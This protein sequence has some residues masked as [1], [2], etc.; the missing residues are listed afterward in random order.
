M[1]LILLESLAD[2]AIIK[3]ADGAAINFLSAGKSSGRIWG[4]AVTLSGNAFTMAKGA[5]MARGYRIKCDAST[6][7]LNLGSATLPSSDTAYRLIARVTRSGDSASLAIVYQIASSSLSNDLIEQGN[8]TYDMTIGTFKMGPGGVSDFA[9]SLPTLS[10]GGGGGSSQGQ[11]FG[12]T[13]PAPQLEIVRK[14]TGGLDDGIWLCLKNKGDYTG[15]MTNYT[16]VLKL[17]R[18]R[19]RARHRER[20]GTSKVYY[21]KEGWHQSH[22]GLKP[23]DPNLNTPIG[24]STDLIELA[25][26]TIATQGNFSYTRKDV[27]CDLGDV[28]DALWY[29]V[30]NGSKAHISDDTSPYA[31]R[32]TGS[33]KVRPAKLGPWGRMAKGNFLKFAFRA[34]V[35][36]GRSLVAKSPIGDAVI[37][38]PQLQTS[39][40]VPFRIRIE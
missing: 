17:F 10:G 3:P 8:G 6:E 36:S 35:Y 1:S 27:I 18:Y 33:K 32:V 20:S 29:E 30:V 19:K 4:A 11:S 7:I 23:W 38:T 28:I 13:L 14:R 15:Y 40:N 21:T 24:A 12:S 26:V 16:V 25:T 22:E 5:I 31:L 34:Y 39:A 9:D 2:E 37:I